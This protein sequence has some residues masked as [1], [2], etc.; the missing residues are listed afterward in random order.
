M[1]GLLYPHADSLPIPIHS[2]TSSITA[3]H[4]AMGMQNDFKIFLYL[5]YEKYLEVARAHYWF[6]GPQ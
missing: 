3:A 1:T 6:T 5:I 2:Y 4:I